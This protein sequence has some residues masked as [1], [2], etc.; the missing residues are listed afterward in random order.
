MFLPY[1]SGELHP[2]LNANARG[3]FFGLSLETSRNDMARAILEGSAFA[4]RHNLSVAASAGAAAGHIRTTGGPTQSAPW[5][6]AIADITNRP[7]EVVAGGGAPIGD[8]L[9]AGAGVGIIADPGQTAFE[10]ATVT[11]AYLPRAAFRS[12]YDERFAAYLQLYEH[13][14]PD[15]DRLAQHRLAQQGEVRA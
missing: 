8:A 14:M 2:I 15:F 7:I 13:L 1:L 3:V 11:A 10:N 5:C 4:T 12:L 6:Q 9:L